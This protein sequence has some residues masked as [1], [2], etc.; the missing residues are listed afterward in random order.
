MTTSGTTNFFLSNADLVLEAMDRAGIRPTMLTRQQMVSAYRSLN[1]LFASLNNKVPNLWTVDLVTQSLMAG[2][3]TY[4]VDPN[5]ITVLD[6]YLRLPGG[7]DTFTDRILLPL[8]RTDYAM[9][10]QKD[11]VG[12]PTSFWYDRLTSPTI[13]VWPVQ[14]DDTMTLKYYRCTQIQDS[15]LKNAQT[16]DLPLR[17]L[18]AVAEELAS[19]LA[20]K[21]MPDKWPAL[22]QSAK[23][24]M[25][26]AIT[27]DRERTPIYISPD[28]TGYYV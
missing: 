5:T 14:N 10:P 24:L 21:Y 1:L 23:A 18:D 17:F 9:M 2:V 3:S 26:L 25:D 6:V 15:N 27:E 4:D 8:S 19:R 22:A 28:F 11:Q 12:P 13:T 7:G 20:Q 16:P